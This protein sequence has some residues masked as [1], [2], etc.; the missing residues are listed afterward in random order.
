MKPT[1]DE[2]ILKLV[3][4]YDP[5]LSIE[6]D[7][8][9]C[10]W[11]LNRKTDDGRTHHVFFIQSDDGSFRPLDERIMKEIYECDIWRHFDNAKDYHEFIQEKNRTHQLKQENLRKEFLQWQN[12]EHK[13]EWKAALENAQR[14][15][16]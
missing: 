5:H 6:W 2:K 9:K 16:L 10:L 8:D 14:G 11:A 7:C 13:T 3:Q 4:S 15:R 1:L 12:K